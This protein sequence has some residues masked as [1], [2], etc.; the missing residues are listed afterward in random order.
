MDN[1]HLN[2][3]DFSIVNTTTAIRSLRDSGYKST[4]YALAEL[5]DNALEAGASTIQIF[6][7]SER[8]HRVNRQVLKELAV[9]DNG[10]GMHPRLLRRSL[11]Y[12]D[13][14]REARK[15]MG[16]F[17]FGLPNS[18]MSQA[19]KLDVW[20]WQAGHTNAMHTRLWIE[21]TEKGATNISEPSLRALPDHYR[22]ATQ[23]EM[24][25]SGTLVVWSDLDRV[26]WKR[27]STTFSHAEALLGRLYRRF[28]VSEDQRLPSRGD[29][30]SEAW[31]YLRKRYQSIGP[32]RFISCVPVDVDGP[33]VAVQSDKILH[34]RA[35]DPLYLT[36]GTSCPED[37][38]TGPM[39][40]EHESSPFCVPVIVDNQTHHVIVRGSVARR[41]VR[42][43]S[44]ENA[45]WQEKY[46]QQ[47]AGSTPW[48][49]HAARNVGVSVMRAHREIV[50]DK[51]WTIGYDPRERWWKVEVD[52]PTALDEVFGVTNN[53]QGVMTFERL[54]KVN[55][56]D[57]KL[58]DETILDV[59]KRL[60]EDGDPTVDLINL[61]KQ[62]RSLI[63]VLRK[64]V[65]QSAKPRK[66]GQLVGPEEQVDAR[67]TGVIR[68]RRVDSPAESDFRGSRGTPEE[69]KEAQVD[70][71]VV[72]YGFARPD[73]LRVIQE[74]LSKGHM[75]R[76][77][78]AEQN[79]P[80]FFS[81]DAYPNCIQVTLN[82]GHP[83]YSRLF[84]V[85]HPSIDEMD[86]ETLRDR[87]ADASGAL[88]MLLYA[89]A[90]Y[91]DEQLATKKRTA[92]DVRVEWGKYAEDFFE[93]GEDDV[94]G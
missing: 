26:Q 91:E 84:E 78:Q 65:T 49:K 17:G 63:G 22:Q 45:E 39:F 59:Q 15:G 62:I 80:A 31:P 93:P 94:S 60:K 1:S 79:S 54:A 7:V 12:G 76:W 30:S 81:V 48:G 43:P 82:T 38:G 33:N 37:F 74:T 56:E 69:Q 25:D 27:A 16:R 13:G 57:E 44:D 47:D 71:L 92:R 8:D 72:N 51:S 86:M 64:R 29:E 50:L 21:D 35:N 11:R 2:D 70:G 77:L 53:K 23:Y 58:L 41:H 6:G 67:A 68:K 87:L 73:A 20:S 46:Q 55:L 3:D 83:A 88:R 40:E 14:D 4:T 52:F 32:R 34:V 10:S 89:Y 18:S 28:L 9:L 75:V 5:V 85:L 36:H 24:G 19:K 42:N 61:H 66:R 90:R